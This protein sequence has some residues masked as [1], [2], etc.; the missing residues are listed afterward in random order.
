[1]GRAIG[2][3]Q[4]IIS[5]HTSLSG[6]CGSRK[7]SLSASW[8]VHQAKDSLS[9][10]AGSN[11][12]VLRKLGS[13]LD[14]A[15][16]LRSGEAP[17][18]RLREGGWYGWKP[19]SSSNFSIRAFRACSLAEVRQTP[20]CRA[21]RGSSISVSNTLPPSES[22]RTEGWRRRQR[23][24]PGWHLRGRVVTAGQLTRSP[25]SELWDLRGAE[26]CP[27]AKIASH[28]LWQPAPALQGDLPRLRCL[29]CFDLAK[30]DR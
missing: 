1:M 22:C 6:R 4:S 2:R 19:S 23:R 18:Q 3:W 11:T 15:G 24:L 9:R 14:L 10:L 21:I 26:E 28:A 20:P 12:S 27:V 13:K 8:N 29:D 16:A 7:Q 30:I 17:S 25:D 5:L